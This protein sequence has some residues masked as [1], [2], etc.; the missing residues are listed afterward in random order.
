MMVANAIQ[1]VRELTAGIYTRIAAAIILLSWLGFAL[2]PQHG[3]SHTE[4]PAAQHMQGMHHPGMAPMATPVVHQPVLWIAIVSWIVMTVAM[5]GPA[6][7]PAIE[8]VGKQGRGG[9]VAVYAVVW[10]AIWSVVGVV[11]SL[12][13]PRLSHLDKWWLFAG[14]LLAAASWQF[15]AVKRLALRDCHC[16]T[17][18]PTPVLK[19]AL[20][21]G[22]FSGTA[23]VGSCWA[24]ML[25]MAL[26][27]AAHLVWMVPL[28]VAVTYERFAQR[29]VAAVRLVGAFLAVAA[30]CVGVFAAL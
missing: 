12:V 2:L 16:P 30:V 10:L 27:P 8:Y 24:M 17:Q 7:L 21:F 25:A 9:A 3:G 20:R 23:C 13:Q 26:A 14:L 18:F 22:A 19:G 29:P 6:T 28:T 11:I 1:R 4:A 15:S 5:M